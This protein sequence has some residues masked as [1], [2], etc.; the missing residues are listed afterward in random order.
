ML[1]A[2][3]GD[4]GRSQNKTSLAIADDRNS[5]IASLVVAGRLASLDDERAFAGRLFAAEHQQLR[6]GCFAL[7]RPRVEES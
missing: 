3:D 7:L 2:I 4:G 6:V 5:L 1:F